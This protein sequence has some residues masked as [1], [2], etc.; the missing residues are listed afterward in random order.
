M[1]GTLSATLKHQNDNK[2]DGALPAS[3]KSRGIPLT[4]TSHVFLNGLKDP[5]SHLTS[6]VFSSEQISVRFEPIWAEESPGSSCFP[7]AP[8]VHVQNMSGYI[9]LHHKFPHAFPSFARVKLYL[10][11]LEGSLSKQKQRWHHNTVKISIHDIQIWTQR[12]KLRLKL[13]ILRNTKHNFM[14][15]KIK[16]IGLLLRNRNITHWNFRSICQVMAWP[17]DLNFFKILYLKI[18]ISKLEIGYNNHITSH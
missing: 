2:I 18:I 11:W 7:I 16:T 9:S 14:F 1:F 6:P 17:V 15:S 10:T 13:I 4:C 8:H 12:S 5:L 3:Y